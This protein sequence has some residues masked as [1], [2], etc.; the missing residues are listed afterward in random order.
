MTRK[1]PLQG[2]E[3]YLKG[4]AYYFLHILIT[5]INIYILDNYYIRYA[6]VIRTG[7]KFSA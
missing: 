4:W 6:S 5:S 7:K 3:N 1:Y 2:K